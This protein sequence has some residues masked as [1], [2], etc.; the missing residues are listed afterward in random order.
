MKCVYLWNGCKFFTNFL[1]FNLLYSTWYCQ[2]NIEYSHTATTFFLI[3][4]SSTH[5]Q[6]FKNS[7]KQKPM[8]AKTHTIPFNNNP[9][10]SCK[11]TRIY[12]INVY[13]R[14]Y[15]CCTYLYS[16]YLCCIY[17]CCKY[18]CIYT[19]YQYYVSILSICYLHIIN[20]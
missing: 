15:L 5:N 6:G 3:T 11:Y 13:R 2:I 18:L 10:N 4:T 8:K 1:K 9:K 20:F 7:W 12:T 19:I 17:L 14:F 16:I